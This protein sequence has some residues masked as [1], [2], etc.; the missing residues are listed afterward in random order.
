MKVY[1]RVEPEGRCVSPDGHDFI[2]CMTFGSLI[3]QRVFCP[4]C[5]KDWTVFVSDDEAV[6]MY[7]RAA[8][9]GLTE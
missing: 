7:E 3:P 9:R 1:E 2:E 5:G 8:T 6:K 4:R